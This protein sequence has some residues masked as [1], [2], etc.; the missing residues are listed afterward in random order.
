MKTNS[1]IRIHPAAALVLQDESLGPP[2]V[3]F[4]LTLEQSPGV[5]GRTLIF[6]D[7]RRR[8]EA[9]NIGAICIGYDLVYRIPPIYPGLSQCHPR[10]I[11]VWAIA[12]IAWFEHLVTRRAKKVAALLWTWMS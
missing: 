10:Q 2:L 1:V 7:G 9:T 4:L 3:D 5:S 11:D 12:P 8:I 6:N